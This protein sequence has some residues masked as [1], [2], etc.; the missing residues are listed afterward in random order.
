MSYSN[1]KSLKK[2]IRDILN[3]ELG[4]VKGA[5]RGYGAISTRTIASDAPMLGD[6]EASDEGKSTQKTPVKVS[7]AFLAAQWI[8]DP[9]TA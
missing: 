4:K 3:E 9:G 2:I 6:V 1:N 8:D 5:A 7:K